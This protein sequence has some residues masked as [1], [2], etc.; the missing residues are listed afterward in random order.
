MVPVGRRRVA[1][2]PNSFA[3]VPPHSSGVGGVALGSEVQYV[4]SSKALTQS[5]LRRAVWLVS[6]FSSKMDELGL[7]IWICLLFWISHLHNM[8]EVSL[9]SPF[10]TTLLHLS[11]SSQLILCD[12]RPLPPRL[13]PYQVLPSSPPCLLMMFLPVLTVTAKSRLPGSPW[14]G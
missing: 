13:P 7:E 11:A 14:H 2:M 5:R 10:F 8:F 3:T 12:L 4:S 6:S 1:S 9:T